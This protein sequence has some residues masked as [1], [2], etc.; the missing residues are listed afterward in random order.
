MLNCPR[1][2]AEILDAPILASVAAHFTGFPTQRAL[3]DFI[4]RNHADWSPIYREVT[5]QDSDGR[6][7]RRTRRWLLA[8]QCAILVAE[9]FRA[10]LK[11]PRTEGRG[12]GYAREPSARAAV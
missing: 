8:S 1:C 3:T 5:E 2:Q 7:R 11:A 9:T 12:P 4:R 10:T 6:H